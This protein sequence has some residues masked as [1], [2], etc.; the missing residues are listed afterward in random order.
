MT[1]E[2]RFEQHLADWLGDGPTGSPDRPFQSAVAFARAHPRGRSL[3]DGLWAA[4]VSRVQPTPFPSLAHWTR[5]EAFATIAT[6]AVVAVAVFGGGALLLN[7]G[8]TNQPAAAGAASMPPV[9]G[10]GDG[11]TV[12]VTV[13]DVTGHAGDDLAVVLY[14]GGKL[15]D[16]D[17]DVLGGF[18]SV[19]SGDEFTTTEVVREP[20]DL[21]VG[22]FPFVTDQA[23]TVAPGRYTLVVWVDDGLNPARDRVPVNTDGQGLF[24]C[25]AVFDVG[26]AAQTDVAVTANL[27]PD[28]WNTDCTTGVAIPG[29]DAGAA[30]TPDDAWMPELEMS[31]PPVSGVGDGQTVDVTVSD[32]DLALI[33]GARSAAMPIGPVD[34]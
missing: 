24:A 11:Q 7:Q 31:M 2:Q 14:G 32:A 21:G 12:S 34:G 4:G 29:T 1:D 30:V 20:G 33:S 27:A 23:L 8:H 25:Q 10:V 18:W 3:L 15:T 26:D 6:I 9:S 28:G 22:R 17:G 5:V 19:I 13:S 16:L